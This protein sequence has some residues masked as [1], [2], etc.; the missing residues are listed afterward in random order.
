MDTFVTMTTLSEI[1][2]PL[3]AIAPLALAESWDNVGLLLGDRRSVVHRVMT[4]LTITDI[5]LREAIERDAQLVIAHHPIPFKP[6]QRVTDET[7]TGKLLLLAASSGV[8][9]YAPHTAWDNATEGIN[10]QLARCL[11]LQV[12]DPLVP[13]ANTLFAQQGLG[14]GIRGTYEE[15]IAIASML[16][17][18]S[19]AIPNLNPR[20]TVQTTHRVQS[21]GIVCGSGG[22]M[23]AL[24]A[25]RGC[26][27]FVTG[28][29]TYHQCLEAQER[30]MALIQIGH[31]AS[32]F[33]S[34]KKF[35][36]LLG[37]RL[38]NIAVF[39]SEQETS[40]Y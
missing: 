21:I 12:C 32:E 1:L 28:E 25:Q 30:G 20:S 22:S 33:F 39:V 9:I 19:K 29:A 3:D 5:T 35:A 26:D 17:R 13:A 31:F 10:R 11:D 6:I 37:E 14:T 24:A 34:M 27:G 18:L 23:L 15:P 40:D 7:P 16:E 36:M 8:A 38:P 2:G 4:C